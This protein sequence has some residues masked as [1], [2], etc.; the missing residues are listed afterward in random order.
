M[1]CFV[2]QKLFASGV[3]RFKICALAQ[4]R[5]IRAAVEAEADRLRK[6]SI[7]I[8]SGQLLFEL[9]LHHNPSFDEYSGVS[10]C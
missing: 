5:R 10:P 7:Q 3:S 2:K 6:I 8:E 1:C 4:Q 9:G